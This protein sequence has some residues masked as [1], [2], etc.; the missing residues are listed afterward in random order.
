[1]INQICTDW[2]WWFLKF[3]KESRLKVYQ[4]MRFIEDPDQCLLL[5]DVFVLQRNSNGKWVFI[6]WQLTN[7]QLN[8]QICTYWIL[9]AY[10]QAPRQLVTRLLRNLRRARTCSL[11]A[12]WQG[13]HI[14]SHS[15]YN[16]ARSLCYVNGLKSCDEC[17]FTES[18]RIFFEVAVL[19]NRC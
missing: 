17:K 16:I 2:T 10:R 8:S 4:D 1:M 12:N 5:G 3:E 11:T 9:I 13:K 18:R 15:E 19:L 14:R 7:L 6:I